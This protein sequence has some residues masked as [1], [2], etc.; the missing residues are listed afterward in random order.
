MEDPDGEIDDGGLNDQ[1]IE[2]A[3]EIKESA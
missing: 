1:Q 2:A 3:E